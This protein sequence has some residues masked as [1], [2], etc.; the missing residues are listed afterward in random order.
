MPQEM[1][2]CNGLELD[3][4]PFCRMC[5]LSLLRKLLAAQV[6]LNGGLEVAYAL[7]VYS[8]AG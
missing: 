2:S 8:Y 7:L 4:Y 5:L 6:A 3:N 1:P